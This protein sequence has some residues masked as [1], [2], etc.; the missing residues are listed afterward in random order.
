M[1]SD[2]QGFVAGKMNK[3]RNRFD[4]RPLYLKNG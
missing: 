1:P 3:G 4:H 2:N